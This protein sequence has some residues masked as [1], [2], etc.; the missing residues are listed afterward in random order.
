MKPIPT[1]FLIMLLISGQYTQARI[2][3]DSIPAGKN[4]EKAIFRLWYPDDLKMINGILVLMP[5]Y[6]GDGRGQIP[7]RVFANR[8]CTL[9]N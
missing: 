4:Y 7:G 2:L 1:I 8:S 3:N 9:D 5:G 6:N